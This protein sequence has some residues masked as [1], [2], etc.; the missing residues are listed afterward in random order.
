MYLSLHGGIKYASQL[1][2]VV[3]R[4]YKMLSSLPFE[5]PRLPQILV[6]NK[7]RKQIESF[8]PPLALYSTYMVDRG[9]G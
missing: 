1:D 8:F 9:Y 2:F 7:S 3:V 5:T 6:P 4:M